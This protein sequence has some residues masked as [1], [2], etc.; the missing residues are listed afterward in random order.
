MSE[1]TSIRDKALLYHFSPDTV[2]ASS[3]FNIYVKDANMEGVVRDLLKKNKL[4][5][6]V[7]I[8]EH[9]CVKK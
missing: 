7:D 1:N 9:F 5:I 3:F 6:H 2:F 8:M 4:N